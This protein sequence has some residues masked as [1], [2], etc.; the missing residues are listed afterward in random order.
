M[1]VAEV[2]EHIR[3][4]SNPEGINQYSKSGGELNIK[5]SNLDKK[6]V[7][8]KGD[9]VTHAIKAINSTS[10]IVKTFADNTKA[11]QHFHA[12]GQ[13]LEKSGFTRLNDS[14]TSTSR[15]ANFTNGNQAVSV[16]HAQNKFGEHPPTVKTYNH[17]TL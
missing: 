1:T 2:R 17:T 6:S 15:I 9:G 4:L 7:D 16:F 11:M 14:G 8:H 3:G 12:V 10:P 5:S 13:T